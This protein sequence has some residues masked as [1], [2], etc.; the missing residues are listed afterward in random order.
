[1]LLGT[2]VNVQAM[3]F[4]NMGKGSAT[5][6]C[7]TRN[8]STGDNHFYGEYLLNAQGEDVVAGI[9]TPQKMSLW[10]SQEWAK[11]SN[12]SEEERKNKYPSL[13]EKMPE[14]YKQLV[15]FRKELEIH[16]KDMQDVEFTI[17]DGKLY[18]LQTRNGKRTGTAAIKMAVDMVEEKLIDKRT[19]LIRVEP[20][21]LDQL[22]HPTFKPNQ[23]RTVLAKGLNAS[24]GASVGKAV[25]TA[26]EAEELGSNGEKVILVRIETS[27][28][29]IKG[30][31]AA[32]GILTA[33]GGATSHAAVVARQMGK[34][35]IAGCGALQID[36]NKKQF[37]TKDG[38]VI[39]SGDWFSL[40]GS[41]GE[42]IKE[43]LDT[44]DPQLTGTFGI[45]M[46]WVDE[47]ALMKVRA[48]ADKPSEAKF[49]R[50]LGAVG[51][52]LC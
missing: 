12:T 18:L 51:I 6:V 13:E 37:T 30:M 29:D 19:A 27:P 11:N 50:E 42:I 2:A 52:G 9:R 8:P 32:V 25:F 15:G 21:Q 23:K 20:L 26:H 39:K 44:E 36:Y 43:K 4:G 10:E 47:F 1:G 7:F 35:C 49:A 40:D 14:C 16:Y 38:I 3:V 46:K 33:R 28:E 34:P 41:T 48:N 17:Q 31:N 45:F 24:P 5:G 22:L